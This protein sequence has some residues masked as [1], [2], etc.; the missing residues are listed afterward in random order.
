MMTFE[1]TTAKGTTTVTIN[2][3]DLT[4][5]DLVM[6]FIYFLNGC[7]FVIDPVKAEAAIE[8]LAEQCSRVGPD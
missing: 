3:P 4:W 6:R 2:D 5:P 8:A 1:C 7:Q